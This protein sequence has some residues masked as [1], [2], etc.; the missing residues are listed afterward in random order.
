[1]DFMNI[2]FID[3]MNPADVSFNI[4]SQISKI[5]LDLLNPIPLQVIQSELY[6]NSS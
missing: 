3:S 5:F 2:Q 1:M 6:S 4:K